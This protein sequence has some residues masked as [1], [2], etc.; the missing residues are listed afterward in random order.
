MQLKQG[1]GIVHSPNGRPHTSTEDVSLSDGFDENKRS[2][3][4]E[5]PNSVSLIEV[6]EFYCPIP[7]AISPYAQ[8][9]D[10]EVVRW[11]SKFE[12]YESESQRD[13]FARSHFPAFPGY[14]LPNARPDLLSL[15]GKE[16]LWLQSFDDVH[17]DE[18]SVPIPLKEYIVLLG[19]LA[20]ILEDPGCRLLQEN[21]WASALRD[22]RLAVG[23][24]ATP[25]QLDR[26]VQANVDYFDG[27]LWEAVNRDNNRVPSLID[28]VAM[29]LK[30][31]GVYPCIVF[32]DIVCA[33]ELGPAD[34]SNPRVRALREM[35]AAIVGW[36]NDLTS[37]NKEIHRAHSRR[38]PVIQNLVAVIANESGCSI[39]EAVDVARMMR[40]RAMFLFLE[41]RD[42]VSAQ[43]SETLRRYVAG[44]GQWIRG[45]LDYSGRSARYRDFLNLS[46]AAVGNQGFC[47]WILTDTVH[48][49][50]HN[51]PDIS[52]VFSW[53]R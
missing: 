36:D 27:L 23:R 42:E 20:R 3:G 4:I 12:I 14:S 44:L 28:Y 13:Y 45:Y 19:T 30:Q 6:P 50:K 1:D 53:W 38:Y 18:P 15:P 2:E 25:V 16:V 48:S 32:T 34:W 46:D 31:S 43:G 52:S 24:Y 33:Y 21:R 35:V 9:S 39:K 5:T 17:S 47:E 26:W 10:D 11:M 22:L 37:Y 7:S 49:P 8:Q 29:W 41:L 51:L 40:D